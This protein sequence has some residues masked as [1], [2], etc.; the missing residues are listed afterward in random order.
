METKQEILKNIGGLVDKINT[1]KVQL[2]DAFNDLEELEELEDEHY[3]SSFYSD[4]HD[5]LKEYLDYLDIAE[6]QLYNVKLPNC[7]FCE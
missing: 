5:A 6:E 3:D 1:L 4:E 7:S 2:E